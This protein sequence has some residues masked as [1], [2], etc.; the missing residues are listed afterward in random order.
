M[1][2]PDDKWNVLYLYRASPRAGGGRAYSLLGFLPA[3]AYWVYPGAGA[4]LDARR[5]R[6]SQCV[7]LPPHARQGHG[8]RLL[9]AAYALARGDPRVVDVAV[10]DPS[11]GFQVLPLLAVAPLRNGSRA[12]AAGRVG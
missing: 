2:V 8:A 7:V 1:Q 3:Y 10:E 9:R 11:E 6:V 4:A 5:L 12:G